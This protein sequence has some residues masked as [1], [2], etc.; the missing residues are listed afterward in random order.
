MRDKT[1]LIFMLVLALFLCVAGSGCT[2]DDD[3]SAD[4]DSTDDDSTDDDASDDDVSDD[5]SADDDSADDDTEGPPI[6]PC[7][8]G[9]GYVDEAAAGDY[10]HVRTPA[11]GGDDTGTG[12]ASSPMATLEAAQALSR[13][14]GN[15]KLLCVGSGDY[16]T[17][18]LVLGDAGNDQTDDGL[19]IVGCGSSGAEATRLVAATDSSW[20][21]K[22]NTAQ[23]VELQ[24]FA[25]E[26]GRRAIWVWGGANVGI[27]D[28]VVQ[29]STRLG[30]I[31]GGWDTIVVADGLVIEDTIAETDDEG[32]EF[33]YG[34][35]VHDADV[36]ITNGSITGSTKAGMLING[37][38]VTM[39]SVD[40]DGTQADYLGYKGRGIQAQN[41]AMVVMD[42][43]EIG[44]TSPNQDAG[45]YA[46]GALWFQMDNSMVD[47]TAMGALPGESC[48][49]DDCPGEGVVISQG[50]LGE[51][52][53][54][55][56][57]F[58]DN[59]VITNS[60]RAGILVDSVATE[61]NGNEALSTN[62]MFD[63]ASSIYLQGALEDINGTY[64]ITGT[65]LPN[66]NELAEGA[67]LATNIDLVEVDDLLN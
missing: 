32:V 49:G 46:Q 54:N 19:T 24:H 5:D 52:P 25:T 23:G 4:D 50:A 16:E 57:A 11:D 31:F 44:A 36:T 56:M 53:A 8:G 35:S 58:L 51:D 15:S 14:E 21:I 13:E 63:G 10:I 6:P 33:G 65:D 42:D 12:T 1:D 26:G 39:T 62:G 20:I 61:L 66:A 67:A 47:G 18:L 29:L 40:I 45:I 41:D 38:Y 17:S 27:L 34:L 37:G 48:G 30:T 55:F 9:W 59:N 43:C 7:D 64:V 3:D 22:I 28:L 2:G 60:A